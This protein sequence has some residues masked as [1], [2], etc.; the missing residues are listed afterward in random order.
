M[1]DPI[2]LGRLKR[3][4]SVL[5]KKNKK[6]VSLDMLANWVGFYPDVVADDLCFFEPMIRMDSSVNMNDLIPLIEDYIAKKEK[7]KTLAPKEKRIVTKTEEVLEYG[8][9]GDFVYRKMTDSGGLVSPSATLSDRD[10]RL[11]QKVVKMEIA[12]RRGPKGKSRK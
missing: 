6:F 8:S 11:L 4:L 2:N 12:K 1:E 7:P 5:K 3:C 10:L 9:V